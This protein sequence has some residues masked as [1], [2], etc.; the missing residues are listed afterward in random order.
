MRIG[1]DIRSLQ[2]D[3]RFRGIGA[4]LSN[5]LR[6]LS[7]IDDENEYLL[8]A[9][10]DR[11]PIS[12]L[13]L[14]SRFRFRMVTLRRSPTYPALG[15]IRNSI[16]RDIRVSRR[17]VDVFMQP[18]TMYGLPWGD[19]PKVAVAYDLIPL[20][21]WNRYGPIPLLRRIRRNGMR[22]LV[23]QMLQAIVYRWSLAQLA[24][25][26]HI[27]AISEATAQ[28]LVRY[29]P[30]LQGNV[31]VTHLSCD[32][33]FHPMHGPSAELAKFSIDR[34]FLL[35]VGGA[36]FR[37]NLVALLEA[38]DR[39][40]ESGHD[41]QLVL[42]G[43]E[44]EVD[45]DAD[46]AVSALW[47]RIAQ[48][49]F[50]ADIIRTGFVERS[51]LVGLYSAAFAFVF[52]SLYEGFG[53][54]ILEA[55]AC[56]CPVVAYRTSSIP[57]VAGTAAILVDPP[58]GLAGAVAKLIKDRQTRQSLIA[59]GFEQVKKFSWERTAAA[60]LKILQESATAL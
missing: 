23:R 18:N 15:R 6:A 14:S 41:L 8:Y 59:A 37:K 21:F 11:D 56:G 53:L 58:E 32:P 34:P 47:D 46:P 33:D 48:S 2:A 36:D 12:T 43:K 26:S 16:V 42:A 1:I 51:D 35:Y 9:W 17:D 20:I 45:G 28:D 49:R 29:F 22:P 31:M 44:F 57:E 50:K 24:A 60:T 40:R 10:A 7:Q 25:A 5:L 13:D 4:Y 38:Y 39:L 3:D 52:P 27:I 30:R 19:V 54:P 55:M